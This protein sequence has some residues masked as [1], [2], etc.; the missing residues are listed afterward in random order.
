MVSPMP[1]AKV[2]TMSL[3]RVR[4]RGLAHLGM[5]EMRGLQVVAA[6]LVGHAVA[7]AVTL[8]RGSD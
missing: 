4:V 3:R 1:S 2:K 5:L 7:L 6:G 8:W